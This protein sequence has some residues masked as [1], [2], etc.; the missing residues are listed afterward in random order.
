MS[1]ATLFVKDK[2]PNCDIAEK[3]LKHAGVEYTKI[4]VTSYPDIVEKFARLGIKSVPVTQMD[5]GLLIGGV[6]N[7]KKHLGIKV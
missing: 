1:E 2:C 5:G 3:I 6:N 4:N 7:L